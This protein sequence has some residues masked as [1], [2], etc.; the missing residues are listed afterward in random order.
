M[1]RYILNK[2]P[3]HFFV[4][5]IIVYI[6]SII[7]HRSFFYYFGKGL[8]SYILR[9]KTS[10]RELVNFVDKIT[11]KQE[12][13][14][15]V[16]AA[17]TIRTIEIFDLGNPSVPDGDWV[18]KANDDFNGALIYRNGVLSDAKHIIFNEPKEHLTKNELIQILIQ[19][20]NRSKENPAR[21][22]RELVYSAI[23]RKLFFEEL[24]F[25]DGVEH[26]PDEYKFH[27]VNGVVQI[28]YVVVDRHGRNKRVM[29]GRTGLQLNI[30][31][32]KPRDLYKFKDITFDSVSSRFEQMVDLAERVAQQFEYVR[33]DV[34]DC[35]VPKVGE[36]TFFHGSG[37]EPIIPKEVDLKLGALLNA[38]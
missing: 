8:N 5:K 14:R 37:L 9:N 23:D 27:V 16:G 33:V 34:Y 25:E 3:C 10:S 4:D 38:K 24:A 17:H 29:L 20:A 26:L 28:C 15:L 7:F 1:F 30:Q 31:W 22:T 36:L 12:V 19:F 32:C 11:A 35:E 6:S 2:I 18:F 13:S 21:I